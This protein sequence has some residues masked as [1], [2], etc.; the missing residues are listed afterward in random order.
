MMRPGIETR[1]PKPWWTLYPL[2]LGCKNTVHIA[3]FNIRILNT[4]NQLTEL[5]V[6]AA[7]HNIDIICI[8]EYRFFHSKLEIKYHDTGNGW[9]FFL[10]ICREKLCQCHHWRS[11]NATQS[12][13]LKIT[14]LALRK[15]N[16]EWCM[17]RLMATHAQQSPLATVP[18][19][20]VIKQ[21]SP[22]FTT[23]YLSLSDIFP[24][25]MF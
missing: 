14:K 6:S 21:T 16:Q 2:G 3:T 13:C 19:M 8:Q 4:V 5:R 12:L 18:P 15:Y 11:R 22:P 20:P 1:S 7:E 25:T 10:N 9:M 24:N 17:L 23:S